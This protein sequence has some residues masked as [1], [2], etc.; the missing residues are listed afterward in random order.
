MKKIILFFICVFYQM[1]YADYQVHILKDGE[2]LSELLQNR[3]YNPLYKENGWVQKT[4]EMNHLTPE[5]AYKI[6]KGFPIL[7]PLEK[8]SLS[9]NTNSILI[10][11]KSKYLSVSHHQEVYFDFGI[12]QNAYQLSQSSQIEGQGYKFKFG[13]ND[14]NNYRLF[15]SQM[16][17]YASVSITNYGAI[18]NQSLNQSISLRPTY[19]FTL[20]SNFLSS[21]VPFYFGP[22]INIEERSLFGQAQNTRRDQ[23]ALIGFNI[24]KNLNLKNTDLHFSMAVTKKFLQSHSKGEEEYQLSKYISGFNIQITQDMG[25]GLQ[26]SYLQFESIN[27]TSQSEV[28]LNF[29]YNLH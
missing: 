5:Q 12:T 1:S 14:K 16:N 23:N 9:K 24:N 25:I 11:P 8:K 19:E 17:P 18:Y 15:N 27:I 3:G 26:Y 29:I 22:L 20:G 10:I 28:G 2:T 13:V 6:K 4:L 21:K 7:L